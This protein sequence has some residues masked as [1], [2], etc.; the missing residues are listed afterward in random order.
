MPADILRG[1]VDALIA[2]ALEDELEVVLAL[3]EGGRDGWEE[4]R[5]RGGFPYHLREIPNDRGQPLRV[6]AAWSGRMGESAAAARSQALIDALDPGC[7]AVCGVCAGK[8]G[9]VSLGDLILADRVYVCGEGDPGDARGEGAGG[10]FH[11]IGTYDLEKTW[12]L[13][14]VRFVVEFERTTALARERPPSRLSQAWWLRHAL[15]ASQLEGGPPPVAHPERARRCPG[16]AERIG[17]LEAQGALRIGDGGLELT[18]AGIA[19]VRRDRVVHPDGPPPARPLRVH[20]GPI[21][22]GKAAQEDPGLLERLR[23][24]GRRVLGAELES[25]AIAHVAERLGRRSIIA[26]AVSDH[27]DR[28]RDDS[29]RAFA[30]RASAELLVAFLRRYLHPGRA[31]RADLAERGGRLRRFP[32][33]ARGGRA[34]QHGDDILLPGEGRSDD[35]LSRVERVCRLREPEGVEIEWFDA[36]LPFGCYLRVSVNEGGIVRIAPLAALESGISTEAV[37]L[38]LDTI[39]ASYRRDDPGLVSTLVYGGEPAPEELVR[40]AGARRVRLVRFLEYQGLI[41]FRGYLSWQNARLER[42]PTYPPGLYVDQRIAITVGQE[43][44]LRERALDAFAELLDSEHSRFV[45]V[46]GDFGTG[47]TFLL[48]ELARRMGKAGGPL[49]PVLIEMRALEKARDLNALVAQHLALAGM[50]KIDLPAFRHM[51]AEGRI[52]LLFDGFDELAFRVTYDRAVEHFDTLIQAAQGKAAKVVVTSRSQHFISEQQVR[53]A[54][55]EKAALLPGYRLARLLP[56]TEPQIRRFLVNRLGDEEAAGA[57]MQLLADVRDL[58]G[59][60]ANPR[61]LGFITEIEEAQ[62]RQAKAGDGEITSA[63]L[64]KLL[65]DRWLVWEYERA[66][67]KGAQPGLSVAQRWRAVTELALRLWHRTEQS[68]NVREL[69]ADLIAALQALGRHELEVGVTA[70]QIG[71][72][73]LLVWDDQENFR[74]IHQS[75]L[76]WLVAREAADEVRRA[77]EAAALAQRE[78]SD[79][80]ADFFGALAGRAAAERWVRSALGGAWGAVAAANALRIDGR[81]GL[82]VRERMNLAGADLRGQDLSGKDL[83]GCD[84]RGAD[85][86]EAKLVGANLSGA[87]M[88]GAL[89]DG[90]DLTG[91]KLC[92]ADLSGATA[93]RARL[94]GADLT[95]AKLASVKLRGAKLVGARGARF[96]ACDTFGAAMPET[97]RVEPAW[98]QVGQCKAVAISPDGELLASGYPSGITLWDMATHS[99]LR[100]V[101]GHSDKVTSVAFSPDGTL[102]ASGSEDHTV[103]LWDVSTGNVLCVLKGHVDH[104]TSVAFSPDGEMLASGSLDRSIRLW[105]VATCREFR[106]LEGHAKGVTAVAFGLRCERLASGSHDG[107]VRLWDVSTGNTLRVLE[108]HSTPV[109]SVAASPDGEM[110]ASGSMGCSVRLWK[111]STGERLQL[112]LDYGSRVNSVAFSPDG[113][114]LAASSNDGTVQISEVSSGSKLFTAHLDRPVSSVAFSSDGSTLASGSDDGAVRL[115]QASTGYALRTLEG[116]SSPLARMALR[117]DGAMVAFS[118]HI[119][120]IQLWDTSGEYALLSLKEA[121][122]C[123]SMVFSADGRTL[124]FTASDGTVQLWQP[125]TGRVRRLEEHYH[126]SQCIDFSPDGTMLVSGCT[127]RTV[128][129]LDAATGALLQVLV[130]HGDAVRS[131][132]FSSGGTILASGSIDQTVR[133]WPVTGDGEVEVLE[134]HR[135]SVTSVAFS[136]NGRVLASGS[137]DNSVRIWDVAS[138][139]TV[140]ILRGHS[141]AIMSVAFSPEG[142]LLASGSHDSSVRLWDVASGEIVRILRGHSGPIITVAFTPDGDTLVS[143]SIDSTIRF[144]DVRTGACLAV[145]LKLPEGWVA[146]RTDGRY[147][148]GGNVAGGFWHA[149]NLCRFE[150]GELDALIPGLRIPDDEPLLPTPPA[151]PTSPFRDSLATTGPIRLFFSYSHKDEALRDALEAHLALLKRE[152][153]LQSWHDRRIA[154]GDAW[155]GQIDK[156]LHEADVILLLVS[157]DFLA[158]DYCFDREMKRALERHDAGEARV[159]PVIL[160]QTDWHG[161]PFARLQAL[162][163][164]GKPVTSWQNQDEAWTEVAKGIRRAVEALRGGSG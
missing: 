118:S 110:L 47:K 154:A 152:G 112:I 59:L 34:D 80:M 163:K 6:A 96:D 150:P 21:A 100:M 72:G 92:G 14:V 1:R 70:H 26:K 151:L 55:A 79:L 36:P 63:G 125:P 164:G 98:S 132:T 49:T 107:T 44:A 108:G 58:L 159:I 99:A 134:G 84:L 5:D 119:S 42:D 97:V 9:E 64:Y 12:G 68:V 66:H 62:L 39:D 75:V 144:W 130:G 82:G 149:A 48:H 17:E 24:S 52:A 46:L 103:R 147:K 73:T 87:R 38:F 20:I 121:G 56:F 143:S 146:F 28:D 128:R 102:L 104:V 40:Y 51:L 113:A 106:M 136:P 43:E 114:M 10:T 33:R 141:D 95:V 153:L 77:G 4:A 7:L 139:E 126:H 13:D 158:S 86:R 57:R 137:Y 35:F 124:A 120:G 74:F 109:I 19:Q 71:S 31:E 32:A 18:E 162:P 16:W 25:A 60:S 138:G 101:K 90:A 127:D 142:R 30:C 54:L 22:A 117:R 11:E 69:P 67:P 116:H 41:D 37:T 27:G 89:L 83:S 45:L 94:V 78:V 122:A 93:V 8:R 111:A 155:A 140:L 133:I 131:V 105:Q 29:V 65:L 135:Q 157:A 91:A 123:T 61:M 156:H 3:G 148:L 115:W 76:E 81:M 50:G 15:Y 161:A 23:S 53:S 85:L 160:R 129:I 2:T 145:L 88:A